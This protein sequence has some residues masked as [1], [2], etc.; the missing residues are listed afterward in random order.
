MSAPRRS[1]VT[2]LWDRATMVVLVLCG[3][4]CLGLLGL[5][6]LR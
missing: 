4:A 1:A 6:A 5:V 3:L 2:D